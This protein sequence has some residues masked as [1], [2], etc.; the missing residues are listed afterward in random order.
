[1]CFNVFKAYADNFLIEHRD[2]IKSLIDSLLPSKLV[3][4]P[5]M[6]KTATV[7]LTKNAEHTVLHVKATY[8]EHKMSRGIIE[9]HVYMKSTPVS[10]DG[11][12]EVY[13]LP[14]MKKTDSRIENG[15]TLFETGDF[16]GYR[17]FL[18]K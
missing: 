15:R 17:A 3:E 4:A 11:E 1:V 16:L 10:V 2:L 12:Y 9:E 18:L 13:L 5:L 7:A 8:P 6:P 14:E